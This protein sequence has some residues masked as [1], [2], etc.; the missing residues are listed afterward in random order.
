[1]QLSLQ[2]QRTE[3]N[4]TDEEF[5]TCKKLQDAL[6]N[7]AVAAGGLALGVTIGIDVIFLLF[8]SVC[9]YIVTDLRNSF[10]HYPFIFFHLL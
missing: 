2:D 10:Y 8:K 1:M 5:N 9:P 4:W 6:G 3:K 7:F